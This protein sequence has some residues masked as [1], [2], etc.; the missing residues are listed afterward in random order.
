MRISASLFSIPALLVAA[1]FALSCPGAAPGRGG[2]VLYSEHGAKGDGVTDDFDAIAR[3]H[4]AANRTGARVRADAGA[5][6][7]I[8]ATDKTA[9]I[10]TDTDW[11]DAKFIIDDSKIA[12][13]D[14]KSRGMH[15]FNVSS[16]LPTARIA[17]VKKLAK[18]QAKIDLSLPHDSLVVVTDATTKRHIREGLNQNTGHAQ[19][20]VLV[21]DKNGG[22]SATTPVA[23][24]FGN[25]STMT[26]HPIDAETLTIRG[27][28][29]TTIAN[30]AESK[31]TYYSRGISVRRS[32]V[33]IDGLR[34]DITGELDHGAPYFGFIA[35]SNC[36]GL[37]VQNCKLSG[38]RKYETIGSAG[39]PVSMGSYDIT[40]NS[41]ANVTFRNC[42][43]VNDI[44]DTRLW[45]IFASNH[46]KRITFDNVEFSRFDAHMGVRNATIKNSVLGH[47]GINII[48]G[49][50]LLVE[51][52]RVHSRHFVNMRPDYGSTWEGVIIIRN[53]EFSPPRGARAGA[54]LVGGA[55]SGR[56]NFGYVCHMPE[57]I[58]ID[59]LVINDAEHAKARDYPGPG[60][61]ANFNPARTSEAYQEK[62]PYVITREVEIKNLT[63]KSGKKLL[64]SDNA[65]MFR[66]VRIMEK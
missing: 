39:K 3:A 33:V 31:Y 8:G 12:G 15:V 1:A 23:W 64:V 60:I 24:D 42:R 44:H 57:K 49:G 27:G 45:G 13:N 5:T 30:Q 21:I 17:T 38:H 47:M 28:R 26:A 9:E 54:V 14:A 7:Y 4:A 37:T 53:C 35:V 29:F 51:N 10:Q 2:V 59:G 43:Q 65:V 56:H 55:N 19:T 40:V 20:D 50:V 25:V 58:T 48:G 6:Y 16:A 52:T 61:F 18:N 34:H 63:V 36:S 32:N 22:V 66:G 62:F 41:S 11:G 46:S